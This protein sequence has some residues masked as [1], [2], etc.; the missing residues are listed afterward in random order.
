MSS[1]REKFTLDRHMRSSCLNVPDKGENSLCAKKKK[2]RRQFLLSTTQDGWGRPT[3]KVAELSESLA[4]LDLLLPERLHALPQLIAVLNEHVPMD[5]EENGQESLDG[6]EVLVRLEP[7]GEG[8]DEHVQV[9]ERDERRAEL[10]VGR[11]RGERLEVGKES[12]DCRR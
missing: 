5:L 8:D 11:R 12:L 7:L 3:R 9:V 4:L 1:Q 10:E 6:L 2:D